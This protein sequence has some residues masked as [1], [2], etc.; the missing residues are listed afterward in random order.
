MRW[1]QPY[2]IGFLNVGIDLDLL[3]WEQ[4]PGLILN[5]A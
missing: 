2:P 1:H 5:Q 4:K 3:L